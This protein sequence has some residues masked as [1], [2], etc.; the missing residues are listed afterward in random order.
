MKQRFSIN[1]IEDD[2]VKQSVRVYYFASTFHK[3]NWLHSNLNKQI[4]VNNSTWLRY[5]FYLCNCP[6]TWHVVLSVQQLVLSHP[7][8]LS[9]QKIITSEIDKEL[10]SELGLFKTKDVLKS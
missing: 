10:W 7:W 3:T 9:F 1:I 8:D 2:V 4:R 5:L 6:F